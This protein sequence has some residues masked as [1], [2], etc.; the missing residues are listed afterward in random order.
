MKYSGSTDSIMLSLASS[1]KAFIPRACAASAPT[2][3]TPISGNTT[4]SASPTLSST[5]A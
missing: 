3:A 4:A 1:A 2:S 5:A